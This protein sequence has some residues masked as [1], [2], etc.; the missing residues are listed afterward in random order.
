M[1]PTL[2]RMGPAQA[3]AALAGALLLLAIAG[4]G[5]A[6]GS[7]LI[8]P[9]LGLL[10]LAGA[11]AVFVWGR[12]VPLLAVIVLTPLVP[13]G[14]VGIFAGALGAQGGNVRA[15]L[16]LVLLASFLLGYVRGMPPLPRGLRAVAASLLGLA[17]AGLFAALL[18]AD[19]L[20]EL[21]QELAHGVGQPVTYVLLM[22]AVA[23]ALR[24]GEGTRERLLGAFCVAVILQGLIVAAEFAT[25]AAFDP[26][27]GVTRAQG[28]V[29]AN[30]LSAMAML[31]FFTA[32]SL[33]RGSR[34]RGLSLLAV[35]TCVASIG[36]L[37]LATTRG[38]VI[39]LVVGGA[40]LLMSGA[41]GRRRFLALAVV[42]AALAAASVV[43][44]IS[45]LW[46][47]RI[48]VERLS[49]F[50]RLATWVSG[51]RMGIDDPLTGI[52]SIEVEEGV[53][54]IDRY[55]DTPFGATSVVPHNIWIL[56]FA[57]G[58]IPSLLMSLL[59]SLTVFVAVWRRPRIR[60]PADKC[61]VAGI[62]GIVLIATINNLFTHPEVMVPSLVVLT[63]LAGSAPAAGELAARGHG[64]PEGRGGRGDHGV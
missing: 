56:A 8:L 14:E 55:R 31:G 40:Y 54:T 7:P 1:T 47:D 35:A 48:D 41:A 2:P 3:A 26:I 27:R 19:D 25:G 30:F 57:E 45:S 29:G 44:Q 21:V 53:A 22:L 39:G 58:G 62:I 33:L 46:T 15:A 51:A 10:A 63:I 43:P 20:V 18:N 17:G 36:I 23:A 34:A 6:V 61:L 24:E 52:G 49:E 28:T 50:D 11:A 5:T 4:A 32:L 64:P 12:E 16:I 59:F 38:G 37:A 13:V 42:F 9:A 60:S